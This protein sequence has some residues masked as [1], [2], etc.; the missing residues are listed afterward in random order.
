MDGKLGVQR[1]NYIYGEKNMFKGQLYFE[2]LSE[3]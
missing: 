2:K 1:A 3:F